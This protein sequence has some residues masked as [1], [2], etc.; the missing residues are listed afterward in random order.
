MGKRVDVFEIPWDNVLP[1]VFVGMLIA[2]LGAVYPL[3]RMRKMKTGVVLRG[4]HE[5]R[6]DAASRG[7]RTFAAVLL[8][9]VMP[10]LYFTVA[11]VL[12]ETSVSLGGVLLLGA[13]LLMLLVFLP[14]IVPQLLARVVALFAR[15]FERRWPLAGALAART[16]VERPTR[17][18]VAAVG[19][20]MVTAAFVTLEGMT[21]SLRAE[22]EV[23]AEEAV[24]QKI[25]VS[26]IGDLDF[27]ELA[28]VLRDHP[29][30]I[31]VERGDSRHYAPFLVIGL[32]I[33]QLMNYG[34]CSEDVEIGD[35]LRDGSGMIVSGRLA[36]DLSLIVGD[37]LQMDAPGGKKIEH[38]IVAVS[39]TYGYF[40]WPDERMY[41]IVS[42]EGLRR[43]F[44][45]DASSTNR[46]A[47]RLRDGADPQRLRGELRERYA[48]L[49]PAAADWGFETGIARR[50][51][52]VNDI[53]RDFLLFDLI[54]GLSAS[55]ASLGVLNGLLLSALERG[56]EL[57]ILRALGTDRKQVAGM[58]FLETLLVGVVGAVIGL[59]IGLGITPVITAALEDMSG[60]ELP[61]R[62][63]GSIL[64]IGMLVAVFVTLLSALYPI[65]RMNRMPAVKA[66]RGG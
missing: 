9:I 21:A 3:L 5:P 65:W 31:G 39:D 37:R 58:V 51:F 49:L 13:G 55:L 7:F 15:P 57:G 20:A 64:V 36:R 4:D 22:L 16:M 26:E 66:I 60:L 12:G 45:I 46:V 35:A 53:N 43:D 42:D 27:D 29:D 23:W 17:V 1:L 56:K 38:E 50:D 14:L 2:L 63:G 33:D 52:G 18:S 54:I 11:P 8:A 61:Y 28:P 25:F 47:L 6:T 19:I 34:P 62:S 40:P 41:A 30:V 32:P 24:D 48:A 10:A 44:C 59:L